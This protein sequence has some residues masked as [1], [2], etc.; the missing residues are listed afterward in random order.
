MQ[1]PK[2]NIV[3]ATYNGEKFIKNQLDSLINQTYENID[4]YIRD[5]GSKDHTVEVIQ[6]YIA[7]NTSKKRIILLDNGGINLRCPKSFYEIFKKCEPADYYSM[8]DQDDVWYPQKVE[9]AVERLEQE[10]KD[11]ILLYYTACDYSTSEG[12]VLRTSPQQKE[13]MELKDVLY[14]TPGS[15]FTM[16][17]NEKARQEL[18][19]KVTPGPELHDRW[20]V[21]GTVCFG[22]LIYD[23]RS[24]ASHIRHENAVTAGDA[25]N[26][27]L[28]S[29]FIKSE[30]CGSDAKNEKMALQYFY[31][32]FEDR[33]AERQKETLQIF[34]KKNSVI[35]W[36]Q[37]V[38]YPARLRTRI[39]GEIALRMLFFLGKI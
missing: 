14:Y 35:G 6:E 36:F 13:Q 4:I 19:L 20:L 18:L 30:L 10:A 16:V 11:E 17:I 33:L 1:E 27:N 21:R 15:G 7:Q 12:K 31:H 32:L 5:D 26:G 29:N 23:K 39:L 34:C 9:W 38:F 37:K 3:L 8:C 2:V 25:G 24:S 28:L 22:K